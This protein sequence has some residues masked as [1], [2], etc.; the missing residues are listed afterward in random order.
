MASI[1]FRLLH[2]EH[3]PQNS[4][5]FLSFPPSPTNSPNL[6]HSVSVRVKKAAA[7]S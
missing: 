6:F 3:I 4:F 7:F 5:K 2:V 1:E